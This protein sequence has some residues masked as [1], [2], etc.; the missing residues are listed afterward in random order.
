MAGH[1]RRQDADEER[2]ACVAEVMERAQRQRLK[3]G[4]VLKRLQKAR[5]Q[6]DEFERKRTTPSR[7]E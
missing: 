7:P 4:E 5:D 3:V 1:R 2:D 6:A